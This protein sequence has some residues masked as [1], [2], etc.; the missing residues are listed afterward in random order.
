MRCGLL[1]PAQPA[2]GATFEQLLHEYPDLEREDIAQ[3]LRYAAWM[4]ASVSFRWRATMR[5]RRRSRL[6]AN[7]Q[8]FN[9]APK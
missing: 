8:Q 9:D 5:P 2:S 4:L 1:R 3:A 7:A 6:R